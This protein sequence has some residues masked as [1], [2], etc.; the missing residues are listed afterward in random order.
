[1]KKLFKQHSFIV[2]T[3]VIAMFVLI[4]GCEETV[5]TKPFIKLS[6]KTQGTYYNISY[7]NVTHENY[8]QQI[9]SILQAFEK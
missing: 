9:D 7:E 4:S 1:M 3:F 8:K 6:G 5:K 2:Q